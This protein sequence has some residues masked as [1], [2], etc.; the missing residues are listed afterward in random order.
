[1]VLAV[2]LFNQKLFYTSSLVYWIECGIFFN[3][4]AF[5]LTIATLF[6]FAPY[7]IGL[8]VAGHQFK[9][10]NQ[11]N[12]K[13]T[14]V[15]L[16]IAGVM[17]WASLQYVVINF[18]SKFSVVKRSFLFTGFIVTIVAAVLVL[19]LSYHAILKAYKFLQ[20]FSSF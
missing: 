4:F 1:M 9:K 14:I 20:S 16:S 18:L 6:S 10:H 12:D 8:C 5:L 15:I 11:I 13:I 7:F 19:F 17:F 3:V 2:L